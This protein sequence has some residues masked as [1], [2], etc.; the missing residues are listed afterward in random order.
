MEK[1]NNY[2]YY[3]LDIGIFVR[4]KDRNKFE[5]LTG[6]QNDL[7]WKTEIQDIAEIARMIPKNAM[8][9]ANEQSAKEMYLSLENFHSGSMKKS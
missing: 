6:S 9:L 8:L 2:E 5:I 1:T 4:C 3:A 7:H